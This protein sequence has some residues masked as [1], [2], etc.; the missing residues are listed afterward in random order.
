MRW[1]K[2]K[3]VLVWIFVLFFLVLTFW[4]FYFFKKQKNEEQTLNISQ[5]T[6]QE[7]DI[8]I[9][10][11]ES[12]LD[13]AF[14]KL[15][16]SYKNI[17]GFVIKC[18]S[19]SEMSLESRMKDNNKPDIFMVKSMSELEVQKQLGNVLDFLNASQETFRTVCNN[20]PS[21]LKLGLNE[22]N[23]CG[24]PM[25]IRGVGFAVDPKIFAKIFGEGKYKSFL[26]D[27]NNCS[28]DEFKNFVQ[29][30]SR[31]IKN[32]KPEILNLQGKSYVF[33]E[34]KDNINLKSVFSLSAESPMLGA[35]NSA[36]SAAFNSSSDFTCSP[37]LKKFESAAE[38]FIKS[39]EFI[40]ENTKFGRGIHMNDGEINSQKQSAKEFAA[41]ESILFL[42]D[43]TSF[44]DIK[45]YH[46]ELASRIFYVP[47]KIPIK[48]NE[49][50]SN[51]NE[52]KINSGLTVFCPYYLMINANSEKLKIAQDFLTWLKT[53]PVAAKHLVEDFN[54]I[55]YDL[56]DISAID[57]SLSRSAFSF[58]RSNHAISPVFLG[59][60][61]Q[62][63]NKVINCIKKNFL[64]DPIWKETQYGDFAD[65]CL[66]NWILE[67]A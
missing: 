17:S 62:W 45:I 64:A 65:F 4:F 51:L 31:F 19:S 29:N 49:I 40:S 8:L 33:S 41:G 59:A 52:H 39:I 2:K 20:I 13:S 9:Y 10:N 28:Y 61:E 24:I 50:K 43:D 25:T 36:L 47:F 63:S 14:E 6:N 58:L 60:H 67:S 54:F 1:T 38:S 35:M 18:E 37:D 27:L 48:L 21:N 3:I 11:T 42:T 16:I 34:N 56:D 7:Y 22:I 44:R 30:A 12:V 53:S 57:N 55:P 15:L 26:N 5:K 32:E 46:P 23:S 66:N